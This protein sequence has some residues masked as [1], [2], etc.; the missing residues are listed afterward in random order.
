MAKDDDLEPYLEA[1]LSQGGL[2]ELAPLLRVE[3]EEIVKHCMK[4]LPTV[5]QYYSAHDN[6]KSNSNIIM[7][8][9][10]KIEDN[11]SAAVKS[12]AFASLTSLLST[13]RSGSFNMI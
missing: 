12:L 2:M 9:Y 13:M 10:A 7:D 5:L 1:F 3:H 8:I 4:P 11:S 6:I